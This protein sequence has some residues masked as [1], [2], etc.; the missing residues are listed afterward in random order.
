M[1]N[2]EALAKEIEYLSKLITEIEVVLAMG[3]NEQIRAGLKSALGQL[4]AARTWLI[5]VS[6]ETE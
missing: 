5:K 2:K 6:K 3:E 4:R 1:L